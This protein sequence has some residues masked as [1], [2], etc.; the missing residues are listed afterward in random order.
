MEIY[1]ANGEFHEMLILE[2]IGN[3]KVFFVQH[4]N[5]AINWYGCIFTFERRYRNASQKLCL[6][7]LFV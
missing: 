5:D 2:N 7:S 4:L 6:M 3:H 1:A